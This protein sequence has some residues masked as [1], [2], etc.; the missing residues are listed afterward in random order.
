MNSINSMISITAMIGHAAVMCYQK[1]QV[2]DT[3]NLDLWEATGT[4]KVCLKT[5]GGEETLRALEKSARALKLVTA[6]VRDAGHTQ[7]N[8]Q[9]LKIITQYNVKIKIK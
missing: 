9:D 2:M 5:D 4:A 1:A 3:E 8:A 6:V 7:V